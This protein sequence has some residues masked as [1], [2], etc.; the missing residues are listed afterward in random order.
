M[1]KYTLCK[2][3]HQKSSKI[4]DLIVYISYP[5]WIVDNVDKVDREV[6]KL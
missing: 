1:E 2:K 6:E 5:L 4:H 3:N